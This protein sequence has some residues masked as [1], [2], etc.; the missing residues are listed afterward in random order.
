M[1]KFLTMF[2]IILLCVSAFSGCDSVLSPIGSSQTTDDT[3]NTNAECAHNWELISQSEHEYKCSN[4]KETHL[5]GNAEDLE[6]A[7][8]LNV[9]SLRS[10]EMTVMRIARGT[11]KRIVRGT[12]KRIDRRT[13]KIIARRT[14]RGIVRRTMKRIVRGTMK[15]ID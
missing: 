3:L 14:E 6:K 4:C 9:D 10:L 15:R 12:M 11:M 5:C 2:L 7:G 13:M 8:R 1:K